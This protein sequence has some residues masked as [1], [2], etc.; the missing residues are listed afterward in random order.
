MH[1]HEGSAGPREAWLQQMWS[2]VRGE[3]PHAPASVLEIG[4]GPLGGFVPMM[5]GDGHR[6]VGVDPEAPDGPEYAQ[7]EFEHHEPSGQ[8]DAVVASTSLH[9]V[10]D[11]GEVLDA[12]TSTLRPEGTLV[13]V[14][15]ATERFDR[16]TAQWCFDRLPAVAPEDEPRWLQ[17][18]HD[19]WAASGRPWDDYLQ[20]WCR[21]AGLHTSRDVLHELDARFER[22]VCTHGPYLFAELDATTWADEQAAIDAGQIQATG[23]LYA[24][25]LGR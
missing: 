14:E 16:A 7:T 4:C 8:V 9:H 6:A 23:I 12:V 15:W 11:L 21:E 24:A 18:H 10:G 5:L 1:V 13:V 19:E 17:H 22:R 3:L 25:R 20:S 2:F